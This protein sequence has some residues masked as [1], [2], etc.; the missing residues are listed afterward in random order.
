MT[1]VCVISRD[2]AYFERLALALTRHG[3]INI[4]ICGPEEAPRPGESVVWDEESLGKIPDGR[5]ADGFFTDSCGSVGEEAGK[6]FKY[7]PAGKIS[8]A[9]RRIGRVKTA[10]EQFRC[11]CFFSFS[12]GSGVSLCAEGFAGACAA[13]GVKTLLV[14]AENCSSG[15]PDLPD[16]GV[17]LSD[18][19]FAV[20]RRNDADAA[21]FAVSDGTGLSFFR[22]P[23]SER[24]RILADSGLLSRIITDARKSGRYSMTVVDVS[25]S[26]GGICAEALRICDRAFAVAGPGRAAEEKLRRGLSAFE[27]ELL[28]KTS[29]IINRRQDAPDEECLRGL[30]VAAAL[31]DFGDGEH[32]DQ[33]RKAAAGL[34]ETASKE[35]FA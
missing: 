22:P 17:C 9:L 11:V 27:P 4:R 13:E 15:V 24:D 31:P 3:N 8:E 30:R 28:E 5:S 6:I 29:V 14:N 23:L 20:S 18:L 1:Q 32:A 25:F 21:D 2:F 26:F 34:A 16:G 10:S 12:G 35:L 33:A 7:G 19:L